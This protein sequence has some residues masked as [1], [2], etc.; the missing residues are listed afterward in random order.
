M[1]IIASNAYLATY[2]GTGALV[3]AAI[4]CLFLRARGI[5]SSTPTEERFKV[6]ITYEHVS[7]WQNEIQFSLQ[8]PKTNTDW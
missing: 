4:T 8:T 6:L 1:G 2:F 7:H 5:I 3:G